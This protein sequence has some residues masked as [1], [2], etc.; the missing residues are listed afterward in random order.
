MEYLGFHIRN[1]KG[2]SDQK[3][4][5]SRRPEG[6]V[7]A[8]VGLN[9]SGKTTVLE[10]VSYLERGEK[11]LQS[12]YKEEFQHGDVHDLIPMK[13]KANFSESIRVTATLSLSDSDKSKIAKYSE[14]SLKFIIDPNNLPNEFHITREMQ[15]ENSEYKGTQYMWQLQFIG[16]PIRGRK[17][18]SL[19]DYD[20]EKWNSL[21]R[22]IQSDIPSI[23]YFPT[24][25][26]EFPPRIY[27]SAEESESRTNEYYRSIIKDILDSLGENLNISEHIVN[28]ARLGKQSAERSLESV[29]NK[30]GTAVSRTIFEMWNDMF[31]TNIQRKDI[32]I[33]CHTED[34]DGENDSVYLNFSIKDGDD[35]YMIKERSLGFRWFFCFL[36]FT[37]FRKYRKENKNTLFLFDEPASNLHSR[38]QTQLLNSFEKIIGEEQGKI[39]YSTHS[40]H[41]INPAWLENTYIVS[42]EGA[43]DTEESEYEYSSR[44]TDIRI[45][46]Y[47]EFANQHPD[48]QTY[49]QPILD[50]L[51]YAPSSLELI[52][53]S[54][55]VE[56]KNDFYMLNYFEKV[57]LGNRES[58]S[59]VPGT[60]AN[61]LDTM[62][63]LHLG[64][65][66]KFV[67]LLDDDR[68]G[69]KC[70]RRYITKWYLPESQVVTLGTISPE[71]KNFKM[72]N[73]ISS[74]DIET[75]KD[76]FCPDSRKNQISKKEI[77]KAFQEKLMRKD[78]S[79]ISNE[80]KSAFQK[81]IVALKERL[82]SQ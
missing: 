58:L 37:Q 3:I 80:T 54:V 66:K 31:T 61:T 45:S 10:A 52:S 64:W 50:T 55:L 21:I 34:N 76:H 81:L 20:R 23:L 44:Y 5:L 15:F 56:G 63:G 79:G 39:I 41:M 9:E 32:I 28:R 47:R 18:R 67:I 36:L 59:V 75:I 4:V 77:A 62:I 11:H 25:L 42:N 43:Y 2:V 17:M 57:I 69:R 7:F 46:Q 12:L 6:S 16:K 13:K 53:D 40:Q 72:E 30:M 14:K 22:K 68:E 49:F 1:F 24:F 8:L 51:D 60:G 78:S 70:R 48:K 38:A 29:L 27:V 65:G 35:V 82:N 73:L 26:F 33:K 19:F 74:Q 71:W